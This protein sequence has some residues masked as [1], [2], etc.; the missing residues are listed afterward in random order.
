VAVSVFIIFNTMLLDNE[1]FKQ[2]GLIGIF[3]ASLLSHM[4]IVGRDLFTPVFLQVTTAYNP[5]LL[6]LIAGIGGAMGEISAYVFGL[7][8]GETLKKGNKPDT[9]S[10]W[11][12]K[13]GLLAILF[14]AASPLPDAPIILIAGSSRLS[15]VK[16]LLVEVIGKTFWYS[17]AALVGGSII[18]GLS[19]FMD[20]TTLSII[21]MIGS[22]LFCI[23]IYHK[24]TRERIFGLLHR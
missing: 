3:L 6:G 11:I 4:T 15:V 14:L 16:V 21:I 24:K 1:F 10:K 5:F 13:Y 18:T 2:F 17:I 9:L 20:R 22:L 7:G 19:G 23:A 8:I 12:D